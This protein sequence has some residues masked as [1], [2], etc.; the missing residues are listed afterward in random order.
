M[1]RGAVERLLNSD[2]ARDLDLT[3]ADLFRATVDTVL[4]GAIRPGTD[5]EAG[6]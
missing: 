4:Y 1:I 5:E 2:L 6:S 3:A